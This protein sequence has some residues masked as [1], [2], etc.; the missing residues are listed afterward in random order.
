MPRIDDNT[1]GC[2]AYGYGMLS[3]TPI[4]IRKLPPVSM[5]FITLIT[6]SIVPPCA[7]GTVNPPTAGLPDRPWIGPDVWANPMED[8][9]LENGSAVNTHS[10][11]DR[12]L[13]VLTADLTGKPAGFAMEAQ[14]TPLEIPR[15]NGFI[16]FQIGLRGEFADYRDGAIYGTGFA[17]GILADGRLFIGGMVSDAPLI[18]LARARVDLV[19]SAEPSGPDRFDLTLSATGEGGAGSTPVVFRNT[20]VHASW[21]TGLVSFTVSSAPAAKTLIK[22]PR[23]ANVP[24]I[25]QQRGGNWRAA[26]TD[27]KISGDKV[28]VSPGHA[29]GP[30]LWAQHTVESSG[31]LNLTA[32]FAPVENDGQASLWI[33][34]KQV[35]TATIHPHARV[36]GFHLDG[37]DTSVDHAY[38]IRW[39]DARYSGTVRKEPGGKTTLSVAALSCND[40]TGFPHGPLV[41]NIMAHRPDVIA[42]LG[43]QIYE[44]IGGYGLVIGPNNTSRDDRSILCYLRK[45]YM[46]GWSWREILR[47]TPSFA[48]PDDHDVFHGNV[49]GCGGKLADRSKDAG[50]SAQDSGGYKMS[51]DFVNA[52]HL[53]Q[54][55]VLPAPVDPRPCDSGIDVYFTRWIYAGIDMAILA[56]RQ[57]KSAPRALL[58]ESD[59]VNGW[60]RNTAKQ[61]PALTNPRELDVPEA[62]LL[63]SRQEAF[64]GKWAD[65]ATKGNWRLVFSATPFMCLQSIPADKFADD[66]VPSLPRLKPGAYPESDIPKLDYD[67]NGWPQTKRDRAVDMLTRAG[68][69]HVTGDQHLGSTGQY[70]VKEFDDSAWWI[71]SP[72]IANL[73]P[74]RWFPKDGGAMRRP[75]APKYTGRFEDGFGN[76]ITLH[77]AS[78]PHDIDREPSRLFDKAVGYAILTLDRASGHI[79]LANWPYY[80][81]PTAPAPDNHPYPGWPITIDPKT[82]KRVEG[83]PG[84]EP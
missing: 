49:W 46:H 9:Q 37:I 53:T 64:L 23:P 57:F 54:A 25:A 61:R 38:E 67:S 71:S 63:G 2:H 10:G 32:Q 14:F 48:L 36:A 29:F 3:I 66:V 42:F 76:R 70:G 28:N 60:P 12:E 21:L 69:V 44:P 81:D 35:A 13:V 74:R 79:T 18:P 24:A 59:V 19:L 7:A 73:W 77:A 65:A 43:D 50:A 20:N 11:G 15:G 47:D 17:A 22:D 31:K 30:I 68:A 41:A 51:V 75:D 82:N 62:E 34:G 45:Y 26:I 5:V 39:K 72:A 80:A 56:D 1:L 6:L 83:E 52:V 27:M 84:T 78:N 33:D 8:W 16:G 40:S 4:R 58:P 55:G